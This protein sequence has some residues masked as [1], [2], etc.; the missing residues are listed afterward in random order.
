VVEA[1]L[2]C[3]SFAGKTAR[4]A[5]IHAEDGSTFPAGCRRESFRRAPE[6]C[7]SKCSG[8]DPCPC[9]PA[10]SYRTDRKPRCGSLSRTGVGE[11]NDHVGAVADR[12]N[13]QNTAVGGFHGLQSIA[14]NVEENL[15][16]LISISR[17]PGRT[18]SSCK[19]MRVVPERRSRAAKLHGVVH[20]GVDVE[21]R[22]LRRTGAR[23]SADC[24]PAS[25]CAAPDH[26]FLKR[27]CALSPELS[28]VGKQVG[29]AENGRER[30]VDFVG[31]AGG[32]LA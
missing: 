23:N 10:S 30:I 29:K 1:A 7:Q 14:D 9:Q 17:T 18:D 4:T 27:W 8:P 28:D 31:R 5:G 20:D 21:E 6:R 24:Q 16:Q 32:E 25:L 11:Q 15:H 19:S 22:A 26:G 3:N 2:S 12:F 13:G